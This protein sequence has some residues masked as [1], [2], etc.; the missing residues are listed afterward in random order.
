M[1]WIRRCDKKNGLRLLSAHVDRHPM[2]VLLGNN[3]AHPPP[4]DLFD[5]VPN[6][7]LDLP[8]R[9]THIVS[10]VTKWIR[11]AF[12]K[13][14]HHVAKERKLVL[15]VLPHNYLKKCACRQYQGTV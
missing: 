3:P 7:I 10:P 15:Y 11:S 5:V 13:P 2:L 9:L 8:H 6:W 4:F 14:S 1:S 12:V